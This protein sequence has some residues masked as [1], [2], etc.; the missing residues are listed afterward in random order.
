MVAFSVP[1]SAESSVEYKINFRSFVK[2]NNGTNDFSYQLL[3]VYPNNDT[4]EQDVFSYTYWSKCEN[5]YID[6]SFEFISTNGQPFFYG[7]RKVELKLLNAQMNALL[8][9][10]DSNGNLISAYYDNAVENIRLLLMYTDG[11]QEYIDGVKQSANGLY[12]SNFEVSFTPAKDVASFV[13]VSKNTFGAQSFNYAYHNLSIY[14]GEHFET[15]EG[16][17]WSIQQESKEAGL[18]ASII[19]WIKSIITVI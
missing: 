3:N 17:G 5:H 8:E 11:T 19:E 13:F 10:Y 6:N 2:L 16:W 7:G 12:K 1:A 9:F 4:I 18:L 15:N 14:L